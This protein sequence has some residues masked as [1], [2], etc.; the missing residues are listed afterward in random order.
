M[1]PTEKQIA[2]PRYLQNRV[3]SVTPRTGA[4]AGLEVFTNRQ[5]EGIFT[6]RA[7]GSHQQHTGTG[8]T[9]AFRSSRQLAAWLRRHYAGYEVS[10]V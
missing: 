1:S 7:D 4:F 10:H 6:R 2:A 3:T 9:P 8:Q 5:G